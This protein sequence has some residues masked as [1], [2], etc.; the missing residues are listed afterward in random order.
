[1]GYFNDP[2]ELRF[3]QSVHGEQA[4]GLAHASQAMAAKRQQLG[5]ALGN[6]CVEGLGYQQVALERI[7]HG[8]EA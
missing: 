1:M 4:N 7:A 3:G 6:R 5:A 2:L 8:F